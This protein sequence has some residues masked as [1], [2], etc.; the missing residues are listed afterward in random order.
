ML[1][2][3]PL[4]QGAREASDFTEWQPNTSCNQMA[5]ERKEFYRAVLATRM[6]RC[7]TE[8]RWP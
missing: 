6:P 8:F 2:V 4:L 1:N 5:G 7:S 3:W